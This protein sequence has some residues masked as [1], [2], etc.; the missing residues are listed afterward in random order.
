MGLNT[1]ALYVR[2]GWMDGIVSLDCWS[3]RPCHWGATSARHTWDY[4]DAAPGASTLCAQV[5]Q[6][7]AS[8]WGHAEHGR[9]RQ[10]PTCD[11]AA[12]AS[13]FYLKALWGEQQGRASSRSKCPHRDRRGRQGK[14][15]S[16]A[17]LVWRSALPPPSPPPPAPAQAALLTRPRGVELFKVDGW[18]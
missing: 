15:L 7:E 18:K 11:W 4:G 3:Q 14:T 5:R 9:C 13:H 2:D 10:P 16:E 8:G 1:N 12:A 6:V 17:R